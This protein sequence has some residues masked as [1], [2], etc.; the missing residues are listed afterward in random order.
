MKGANGA[1]LN[2]SIPNL[3]IIDLMD[4]MDERGASLDSGK[5]HLIHPSFYRRRPIV[6]LHSTMIVDTLPIM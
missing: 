4:L 2:S 6:L 1:E 3:S 5:I